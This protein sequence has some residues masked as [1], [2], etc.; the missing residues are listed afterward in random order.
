MGGERHE[1]FHSNAGTPISYGLVALTTSGK[2]GD[3]KRNTA[4]LLFARRGVQLAALQKIGW[5]G[6]DTRERIFDNVRVPR[7][8]C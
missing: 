7:E 3:G 2:A 4:P 1:V 5:H 8:I 6:V